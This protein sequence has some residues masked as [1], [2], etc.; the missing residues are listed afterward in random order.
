MCSNQLIRNLKL[1]IA[2]L[3]LI[4]VLM[5]IG[6]IPDGTR[7]TPDDLFYRFNVHHDDY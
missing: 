2:A 1:L 6:I 5:T 4:V 3:I 7:H